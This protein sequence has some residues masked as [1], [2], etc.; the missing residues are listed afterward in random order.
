MGQTKIIIKY[1]VLLITIIL[2]IILGIKFAYN[3]LDNM[4]DSKSVNSKIISSKPEKNTKSR[5]IN[6]VKSA[7]SKP[8]NTNAMPWDNGK[9]E[10]LYQFMMDWG[11]K[12]GQAYKKYTPD[13]NVNYYGIKYPDELNNNS[14][15]VDGQ[16]VSIGYSEQGIGENDYN[17]VAVYSDA[18]TTN[19]MNAHLYLFT[20]HNNQPVALV[21][22]QNQ[23]A[24]D[25]KYHFSETKNTDVSSNFANIVGKIRTNDTDS[26]SQVTD[27][28][29]DPAHFAATL[30][31]G[32]KNDGNVQSENGTYSLTSNGGEIGYGNAASTILYT[33]NGNQVELKVYSGKVYDTTTVSKVK[34]YY[35]AHKD[36]VDQQ[37][38]MMD[39]Y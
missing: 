21:T 27:V 38:K 13:N 17:V 16:P 15:V 36:A 8:E 31:V 7:I 30:M 20:I 23:G 6:E 19:T 33:I 24:P 35:N 3:G 29:L 1:I 25:G 28:A 5:Q 9:S 18:E 22:M 2:L 4:D 32:W 10:K 11:P 34:D 39:R 26:S 14:T 12:M 37:L